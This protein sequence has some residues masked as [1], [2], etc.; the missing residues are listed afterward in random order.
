MTSTRDPVPAIPLEAGG[1]SEH[2][3]AI[4][5]A[6]VAV[7]VVLAMT[8]PLLPAWGVMWLLAVGVFAAMK[9]ATWHRA[10]AR[11]G[12]PVEPGGAAAYLLAWP[13][14]DPLPFLRR[15]DATIT[16]PPRREWLAA[17]AKT[18]AGAALVWGVVRLAPPAHDLLRGWV[19][20]IGLVL[21]LHCGAFHLV[22]LI[23]RRRGVDV[24]P[25]M[26]G[27]HRATGVAEF[28]GAR[29]NVA[30]RQLA[31]DFAF[32]PLRKRLG[33]AGATLAAFAASGLVH[34]LVISVSARAGYGL[35]TAY[36]LAQG[37]AVLLERSALGRRVGL[38]RGVRGWLFAAIVTAGP[39]VWLFHPPFVRAVMLPFLHAIGAL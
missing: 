20:M 15:A 16:M 31:H 10:A 18:V 29:W 3:A 24:R 6:L 12:P 5:A 8:A 30:F 38:G 32:R 37:L 23:W 4:A 26:N 1:R 11:F 34:D 2:D 35:P 25:I 33:V 22:A 39:A 21:L 9:Y 7:V 14:M 28:W 13:G 27:P 19:G 17:A 36:F